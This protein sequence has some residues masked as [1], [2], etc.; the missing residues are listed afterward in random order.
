MTMY[1]STENA[2]AVLVLERNNVGLKEVPS[3]V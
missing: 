2:E 3:F 1:S